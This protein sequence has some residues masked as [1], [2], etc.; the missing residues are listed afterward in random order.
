[1]EYVI[2]IKFQNFKKCAE[3]ESTMDP[4]EEKEIVNDST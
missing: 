3:F 2:S 1:M 4:E